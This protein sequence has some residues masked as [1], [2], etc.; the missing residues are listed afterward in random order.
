MPVTEFECAIAKSQIGRYIKGEKLGQDV[1]H[2]L[3]S[4]IAACP[5][6][7]ALLE[8]KRNSLLTAIEADK[9]VRLQIPEPTMKPM[10]SAPATP[11]PSPETFGALARKYAEP[12]EGDPKAELRKHL[13][14]MANKKPS[15][16]EIPV[17][18]PAFAH[19]S[20]TETVTL[21][22]EDGGEVSPEA[23]KSFLSSFALFKRVTDTEAENAPANSG[24]DPTMRKPIAY[25]TGLTM[26][27]IAMSVVAKNPT[28]MFG[29]KANDAQVKAAAVST[30]PK[31]VA[32]QKFAKVRKQKPAPK[33][34][35]A[36]LVKKVAAEKA[37]KKPVVTKKAQQFVP[38]D[39]PK[40]SLKPVKKSS[41]K[42]RRA[43]KPVAKSTPKQPENGTVKIYAPA[44]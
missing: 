44:N 25:M 36:E 22:L 23:R 40:R 32:A 43:A 16:I 9:E 35:A 4:H 34:S 20:Q 37:K 3:E 11:A 14:S 26:V 42:V 24:T 8:E 27:V 31:S 18:A 39:T 6:C 13:L 33:I 5:R 10:Q 30:A 12:T 38:T 7:K 21:S 19:K 1:V 41:P 29:P 17:V 2:Q 15:T 28:A